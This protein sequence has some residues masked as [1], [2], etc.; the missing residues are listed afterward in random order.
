MKVYLVEH[1]TW[2]MSE[3]LE[4]YIDKNIAQEAADCYERNKRHSDGWMEYYVKE[5]ELK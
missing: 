5:I 4:A 3:I 2:S 1:K